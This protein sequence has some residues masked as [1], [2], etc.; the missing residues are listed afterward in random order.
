MAVTYL[1]LYLPGSNQ[2]VQVV[3]GSRL[4]LIY[5]EM[6]ASATPGAPPPARRPD[7]FPQYV[8]DDEVPQ[9]VAQA[10]VAATDPVVAG[11]VPGPSA[12]ADALRAVFVPQVRDVDPEWDGWDI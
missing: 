11:L 4:H 5:A 12:T 6:G 10:S 3:E 7:P 2:P 9:L 1:T 8:H